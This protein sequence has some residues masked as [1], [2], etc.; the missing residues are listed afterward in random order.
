MPSVLWTPAPAAFETSNLARFALRNGFDPHDYETLHRWSVSDQGAFWRALW[1]FAEVTGAPG[2][3]AFI[4]DDAAPMI[5][6]CVRL[7][8]GIDLTPELAARIRRRIREDAS[9]RHVPHRIHAVQAIPYTLNGKRV[10]GA[11]RMTLEGKPVGNTAS[12]A[13]P[14]CLEEYRLLDR[15]RA[16]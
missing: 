6:L 2:D 8:D 16:A 3:T 11:A 14:A 12:L 13:N 4:R 15:S 7:K 9:P 1:N 10:E 5:V